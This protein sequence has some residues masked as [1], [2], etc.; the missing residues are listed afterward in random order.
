[1]SNKHKWI[2]I[3]VECVVDILVLNTGEFQSLI[4]R[5]LYDSWTR[6]LRKLNEIGLCR[7]DKNPENSFYGVKFQGFNDVDT[8]IIILYNKKNS[9]D[10]PPNIHSQYFNWN[11]PLIAIM[12]YK[13]SLGIHLICIRSLWRQCM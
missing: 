2:H 12:K 7:C 8:I 5:T 6:E 1:M 11:L 4:T 3:F 13:I 9:E 10:F